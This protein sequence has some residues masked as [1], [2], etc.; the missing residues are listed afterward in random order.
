MYCP[1]CE[2]QVEQWWSYCAMCGCHL[3]YH[4]TKLDVSGFIPR[5]A[6]HA[7]KPHPK[8]PWFCKECGYAPHEPLKHIVAISRQD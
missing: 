6:L 7:F 5:P 4:G 3:A 1:K 2:D 8:W